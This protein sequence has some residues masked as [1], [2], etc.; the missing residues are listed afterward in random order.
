M[1]DD[2][3][4][5]FGPL[6]GP[7][8][9]GKEVSKS[10]GGVKRA[11]QVHINVVNPYIC[12]VEHFQLCLSVPEHLG[13]VSGHAGGVPSPDVPPNARP[14]KFCS[15]QLNRGFH[16]RLQRGMQSSK[17]SAA[18]P[19]GD[20]TTGLCPRKTWMAWPRYSSLPL[21]RASLMSRS[22]IWCWSRR[23][24]TDLGR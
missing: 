9:H 14:E 2:R 13:V 23:R 21:L 10:M 18:P 8:H 7:V 20:H 3:A 4:T 5:T 19:N 11:H 17:N 12:N 24:L 15:Y 16:T 1:V 6:G 22:F